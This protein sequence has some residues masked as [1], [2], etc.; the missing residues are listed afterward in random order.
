[1]EVHEGHVLKNY[2]LREQVYGDDLVISY[3]AEQLTDNQEVLI[4]V[5]SPQVANEPYFIRDF[6]KEV[7]ILARLEHP[8]IVPLSDYWR[9]PTGAYLVTPVT[10]RSRLK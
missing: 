10:S 3:L 1:M 4:R 7:Q 9:D 2:L 6:E 8:H 5:V